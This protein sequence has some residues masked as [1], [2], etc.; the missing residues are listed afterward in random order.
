MKDIC[1]TKSERVKV[2]FEVKI[3]KPRILGQVVEGEKAGRKQVGGR[4]G[5]LKFLK[6]LQK[7]LCDI[8]FCFRKLVV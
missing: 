8:E 6:S 1:S 3:R 4:I 5:I 7:P 2:G